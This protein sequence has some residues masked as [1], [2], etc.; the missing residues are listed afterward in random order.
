MQQGLKNNESGKYTSKS[1]WI[2]T[3]PNSNYNSS[4]NNIL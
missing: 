1:K 3:V 4:N 2:V